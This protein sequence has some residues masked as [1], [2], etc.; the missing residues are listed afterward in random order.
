MENGV[1]F[2]VYS[3]KRCIENTRYHKEVEKNS[4]AVKAKDPK[5]NIAVVTNCDIPATT[6]ELIDVIVPVHNY[7]VVKTNE[8]QWMTRVLYNAFLPFNYSFIIDTHVFPCDNKS[9]SD[10]FDLFQK[11]NIDISFSNRVNRGPYCSGG[12]VLSKWG[13]GSHEFWIRAYQLQVQKNHFDDQGPMLTIMKQYQGKL[14]SFRWLSSNYFFAS[15]GI[16]EKGVFSGPAHCYRSSIV[17]TGPLRWIHGSP[18]QCEIMNKRDGG[19]INKHRAWFSSGS[20][21][22]TA[23]GIKVI[24]SNAEMKK[25]VYPYVA[26]KLDWDD[27]SKRPSTGLFWTV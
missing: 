15:H 1:V 14:F 5:A 26:P 21:K 13:K 16:T 18:S 8:K 17:V 20:C 12:A 25:A 9:Y 11:S 10:I 7:D 22:T 23:R 2:Y 4:A 19:L 24:T 6:A 27:Y 3:Q